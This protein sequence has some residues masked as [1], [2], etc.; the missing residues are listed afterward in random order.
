MSIAAVLFVLKHHPDSTI[1]MCSTV[2]RVSYLMN[3]R[4]FRNF[5]DAFFAK[6][7]NKFSRKYENENVRLGPDSLTG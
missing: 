5:S 4:Y 1:Q 7:E 2:T 3:F 6:S